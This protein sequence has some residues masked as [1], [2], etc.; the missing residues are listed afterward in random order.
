MPMRIGFELDHHP[1]K[2]QWYYLFLPIRQCSMALIPFW[3]WRLHSK[4]VQVEVGN[5]RDEQD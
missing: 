4:Y 3:Q 1:L 2:F 5:W